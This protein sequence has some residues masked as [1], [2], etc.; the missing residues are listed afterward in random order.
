MN[1]CIR[2]QNMPSTAGHCTVCPC[3]PCYSAKLL[4]TMYSH[5][6]VFHPEKKIIMSKAHYLYCS[7]AYSSEPNSKQSSER[8]SWTEIIQRKQEIRTKWGAKCASLGMCL[9][10]S[11]CIEPLFALSLATLLADIISVFTILH[12]SSSCSRHVPTDFISENDQP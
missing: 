7:C 1:A 10:Y 9:G 12:A 6:S 3:N 11:L 2:F 8:P 4:I 5:V